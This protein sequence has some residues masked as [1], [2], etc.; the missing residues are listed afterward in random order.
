MKDRLKRDAVIQDTLSYPG[1]PTHHFNVGCGLFF[2]DT[3]LSVN[4]CFISFV[5]D[6]VQLLHSTL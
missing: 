5:S 3:E 1:H 2:E 4:I 6:R